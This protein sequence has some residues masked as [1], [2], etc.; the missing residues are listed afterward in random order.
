MSNDGTTRAVGKPTLSGSSSAAP[1]AFGVMSDDDVSALA[2]VLDAVQDSYMNWEAGGIGRLDGRPESW[3]FVAARS[4]AVLAQLRIA[5]GATPA[6]SPT[7]LEC[8]S[9]FGFVGALAKAVGFTVTCVEVVPRYVEL[10]RQLFPSVRVEETDLLTFDR[11]GAFD[12]VYYHGPFADDATQARFEHRIEEALRPGGIVLAN[13]KIS[14][15]WRSSGA[16][17]L[18]Y[19]DDSHTWAIQKRLPT[20]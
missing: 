5:R 8:G 13:R 10:S 16:F 2:A 1:L 6:R 7:F 20:G 14:D 12:V 18:L 15:D 17:D 19:G 3:G 11:F 4:A 9:G